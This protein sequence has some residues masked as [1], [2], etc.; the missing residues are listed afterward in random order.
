M[1]ERAE[2]RGCVILKKL[3]YAVEDHTWAQVNDDGT[4][5]VGMT[6]VAQ[7]MAGPI[8]HARVKKVGTARPKGRPLATVESSK[9][10]GPVKTPISG[11]IVEVNE[12]LSEDAQLINSSPYKQGW[13]LKLKPA[14]L[15]EE[16][17][18][19]VTGDAAVEAYRQKIE[20]EDIKA[21]EHV[22]GFED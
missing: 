15:D 10:V 22:E 12:K 1:S 14:N 11:E 19:M 6:D 4:V 20:K 18:D 17:Q 7:N 3:H 21:C 16:L 2:I 8:L 5:T 13:L 9:W